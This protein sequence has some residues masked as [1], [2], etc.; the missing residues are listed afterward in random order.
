MNPRDHQRRDRLF[1]RRAALLGVGQAG[2][3][4]LLVGRLYQL[5]VLESERYQVL[6]EENRIN[7]RLLAPPR[8]RILDRFGES[9]AVNR[10]NYRLV[11]VPEQA[12]EIEAILERVGQL[13]ELNESDRRRVTREAR[14]RRG[15]V[16]VL[17]REDLTW[18]E[19]ARIEINSPELPGVAIDVGQSRAY[20]HTESVGHVLG[21]VGAVAEAELTGEPLLELPGFKIGKSGVER[22]YDREMRGLAGSSQVEVNAFGRVIRELNRQE[23]QTGQDL[24]LTLDIG[25][26][27]FMRARVGEESASAVLMDVHGGDILGMVSAPAFDPN[28]FA[29][30]ISARDWEELLANPK[31]PLTNK[32]IA[33]Q[34]SP[35]STFKMVVA[36]A[37]LEANLVTTGTI[38]HCPGHMELGDHRFHC[39]KKEG[40][41]GMNLHEGMKVSCDVYF[42]ELAKRCGMNR[43]AAMAR[44][45]GFGQRTGIDLPNERA[46]LIPTRE[47]YQER[48]G[49]QWPQG[50]TLNAGIGQGRVLSTPLQLAVMT[51]RLVNGGRAV[52]P[53]FVRQLAAKPAG[54]AAAFPSLGLN[55]AH[56]AAVVRGMV[57]V[58]NEENGTG[59]KVRITDPAF[60]MGG[61]SGT[62]QVRRITLQEREKGVRKNEDLPWRQR[63]HALFVAYAPIQAPRYCVATVV[64]HGGGGSAVA[65]PICR[66]ILIE[67]QKRDP[68]RRAPSLGGQR[69]AGLGPPGSG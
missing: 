43:I 2:L 25:L 17:V 65:A 51:A 13:V 16:P 52:V 42:Y 54:P 8:G 6:A 28:L 63:D 35:G 21:H 10:L 55:P 69:V 56:L 4:S 40:H 7:W 26:Q 62:A 20:P 61:K 36:L 31:S 45:L 37:A 46:G 66:D 1:S 30:G 12:R 47:W 11:V 24:Q 68:L 39:W 15:F 29:A 9:L 23:G 27:E 44:R 53:H 18:D 38:V 49:R 34:Y 41:G 22:T 57:G 32:P 33:G 64:E 19:V 48:F 58:C 3:L 67:A 14:R 60:A 50:E 5:Q 59:Y